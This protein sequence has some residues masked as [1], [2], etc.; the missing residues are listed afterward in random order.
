M[1]PDPSK[2]SAVT[3]WP[4]LQTAFEVRAFLGLANYFRK[5]IQGFAAMVAPLTDLLK[6]LNKHEKEGKLLLRGRLA[7]AAENAFKVD[8]ASKWTEQAASA[9]QQVKTALTSAPLLAFPDFWQPFEVVC[10]AAQ[11]PPAVGAVLLQSGRPIAYFSRKLSGAELNYSPS[12]IEMLALISAL[13]EWRCYL[14]GCRDSFTLLTDH[15]P[16]IYLDAANNAHTVHCR[17]RW[18]SVRCGYNYKWCYRPG[19]I[20]V[21]DPI[22][23][24]PQHFQHLCNM[25]L[26]AHSVGTLTAGCV[27]VQLPLTPLGCPPDLHKGP[28]VGSCCF[29]CAAAR[30]LSRCS[31]VH[32]PDAVP[33]AG[34]RMHCWCSS[35]W[36]GV[37]T[38]AYR[39]LG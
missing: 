33:H 28:L 18:L 12:D 5:Y 17:A 3:D 29:L 6:G 13:K 39:L 37:T 34:P 23:R 19:R 21:A 35:F 27:P 22:S 4:L 16:N 7:P 26:V 9:F 10:D 2:V 8:F 1:K 20:N 24:A 31:L 25:A 14:K 36:G 38:H 11:T 32:V 15:Q 30:D